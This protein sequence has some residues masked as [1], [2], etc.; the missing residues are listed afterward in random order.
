MT[1]RRRRR[2]KITKPHRLRAERVFL[3]A[4]RAA[5]NAI[6]VRLRDSS[7]VAH[8]GSPERWFACVE[9]V[10]RELTYKLWMWVERR[11]AEDIAAETEC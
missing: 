5:E 3:R 9:L 1:P 7:R 8:G 10:D 11:P 2:P 4:A 6:G